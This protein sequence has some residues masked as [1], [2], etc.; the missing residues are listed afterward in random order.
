MSKKNEIQ[1]VNQQAP[2]KDEVTALISQAINSGVPVETMERL[3]AMRTQLKAEKAKEEFD[4]AM[5]NFQANCPTITKTKAVKTS[6]GAVAYKYA[7][8]DSIVNQVKSI[9]GENDLS[10]SIQTET[11]Q[12][13]VKA[14]CIAKHI[15]GH[16]EQSSFEVPLGTKTQI[17]SQTQVVAAALTFAKRYAF[18]NTFG[19][20]T[21]DE[22]ND[23][24]EPK[25]APENVKTL[26]LPDVEDINGSETIDDLIKVC[27]ALKTRLGSEYEKDLISEYTRRKKEIDE[28]MLDE[29]DAGL[30]GGKSE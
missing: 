30:S 19:I 16:S 24:V 2:I 20:M 22:D 11:K 10:Y 23:A 18:L 28:K 1:T 12:D 6:T 7:P 9:L 8:I 15:A 14:T 29:I 13:M 5:A 3:L 27:K 21:G 17:M 4:K 26:S 25:K